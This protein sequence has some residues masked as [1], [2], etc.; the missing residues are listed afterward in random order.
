[1]KK[2]L[3]VMSLM[4]L[5]MIPLVR[6]DILGTI[7]NVWKKILSLGTLN[8]IGVSGTLPLTRILIWI[9]IFTIFFAVIRGMAGSPPFSFFKKAQAVIIAGVLA[10]ISAIFLPDLLLKAT[11]VGWATAVALFLIGGPIAGLGYLLIKIPG[12]GNDDKGTVLIKLVLVL[13]LFWILS[14]MRNAVVGG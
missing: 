6:A 1:M 12:R 11:G 14:A 10:T 7:G 13:L 2:K 3:V 9:L 8:F 5:L 4:S